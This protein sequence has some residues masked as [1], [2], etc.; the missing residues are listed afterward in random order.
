MVGFW[1]KLATE[2]AKKLIKGETGGVGSITGV[3]PRTTQS[4]ALKKFKAKVTAIEEGAAEGLAKY[5]GK[6]TSEQ[7]EAT[8]KKVRAKFKKEA[9]KK[10]LKENQ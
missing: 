6:L 1:R 10:L 4:G 7:L 8:S 2:G 9:G 5:K 3:R